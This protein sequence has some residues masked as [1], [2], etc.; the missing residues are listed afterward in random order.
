MYDATHGSNTHKAQSGVWGYWLPRLCGEGQDS[1][2]IAA[3]AGV[4]ATTS[5]PAARGTFTHGDVVR[6]RYG[7]AGARGEA[8][9]DFPHIMRF[10][11]PTAAKATSRRTA[12]RGVSLDALFSLMAYLDDMRSLPRRK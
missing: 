6:V 12:G 1:R 10:G 3:T 9:N 7:V 4:I 11:L 5:R 2:A 8:A